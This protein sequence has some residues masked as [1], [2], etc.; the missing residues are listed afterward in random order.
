M[1]NAELRQLLLKRIERQRQTVEAAKG[2]L[3]GPAKDYKH[4]MQ[5]ISLRATI[6]R[7]EGHIKRLEGEL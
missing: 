6:A 2:M 4:L 7:A 5:R 1:K 3:D